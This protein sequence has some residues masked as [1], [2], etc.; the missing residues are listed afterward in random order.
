MF[1][2]SVLFITLC[3]FFFMSACA[4]IDEINPEPT[5]TTPPEESQITI[6]PDPTES[7]PENVEPEKPNTFFFN[8]DD[9]QMVKYCQA[10]SSMPAQY[11]PVFRGNA[12]TSLSEAPDTLFQIDLQT[13][14]PT[15]IA[16]SDYEKGFIGEVQANTDWAV[17]FDLIDPVATT[18]WKL[19]AV[20]LDTQEKQ[21]VLE[22][23]GRDIYQ[24]Q[25]F[26]YLADDAVYI[27]M[28]KF[29]EDETSQDYESALILRYDLKGKQLETLVSRDFD[30]NYFGHLVATPDL[31]IV[32]SLG[33]DKTSPA[34]LFVYSLPDMDLK[35]VKPERYQNQLTLQAPLLAWKNNPKT[36]VTSG[37]SITDIL[38]LEEKTYTFAP[39]ENLHGQLAF[40][41]NTVLLTE[42]I[43]Y[44]IQG[45]AIVL[46]ELNNERFVILGHE[47][48]YMVFENPVVNEDKL[49]WTFKTNAD[50]ANP[51]YHFCTMQ[52]DELY[53][54]MT[55]IDLSQAPPSPTM[56]PGEG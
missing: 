52:I 9:T 53:E 39:V 12:I 2:K 6:T 43:T 27:S 31:L 16:K 42:K 49:Y 13:M 3:I 47:S 11:F 30:G 25:K 26:F 46:Y 56:A 24:W 55:P 5:E 19:V 40:F 4:K 32:E 50:S 21:I 35:V 44:P 48:P 36:P 1:R 28:L 51:D 14:N 7:E 18:E 38:Y 41:D 33:L 8:F 45:L 37:F 10:I 34:E 54:Q 22:P 17:Y 29:P 15:P 20:D 23:T